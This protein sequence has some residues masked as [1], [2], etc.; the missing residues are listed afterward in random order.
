MDSKYL[1][2]V[3]DRVWYYKPT[4][5][6]TTYLRTSAAML[7]YAILDHGSQNGRRVETSTGFMD[8]FSDCLLISNGVDGF[9]SE[10]LQASP[11]GDAGAQVAAS[12]SGS[13]GGSPGSTPS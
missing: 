1:D 4:R 11:S 10:E 8:S 2:V 13:E 6:G 7:S 5:F 9:R 12:L 3:S